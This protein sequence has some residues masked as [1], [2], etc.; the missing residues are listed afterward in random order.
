[1][2]IRDRLDITFTLN[3]AAEVTAFMG[4]FNVNTRLVTF[5]EREAIGRGTHTVIWNGANSDGVL[6]HP[7]GRDSFLFGIFQF[8]LSDNAVVVSS[9]AEVS[10]VSASPSIFIPDSTT[11]ST[12]ALTLSKAADVELLV[13]DAETGDELDRITYTDLVSGENQITWDGRVDDSDGGTIFVAPGRYRLGVTAI[14]PNASRS[15]TV[16]TVQQI[17]Y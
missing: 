10:E 3:R 7:P 1:M 9:G 4:L 15:T 5:F 8:T 13:A 11:P 12:I 2:C 16:F 14:S 6:V 17:Y